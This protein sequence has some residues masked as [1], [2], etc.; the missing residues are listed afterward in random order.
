MFSISWENQKYLLFKLL[1]KHMMRSESF[2]FFGNL[3]PANVYHEEGRGVLFGPLITSPETEMIGSGQGQIKTHEPHDICLNFTRDT[4]NNK[5]ALFL[6]KY[7]VRIWKHY[8][9]NLWFCLAEKYCNINCLTIITDN[10]N[11]FCLIFYEREFVKYLWKS[12]GL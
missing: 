6:N 11:S 10:H 8:M 4:L 12:E 2:I 1:E 9:I 3:P 7:F 5:L